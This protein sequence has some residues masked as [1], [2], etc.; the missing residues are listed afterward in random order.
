MKLCIFSDPRIAVVQ[1]CHVDVF[2]CNLRQNNKPLLEEF[3]PEPVV[4]A[5]VG[6][7]NHQLKWFVT[8]RLESENDM[9]YEKISISLTN[10]V[11][12]CNVVEDR[13]ARSGCSSLV[14]NVERL[15]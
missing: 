10:L 11:P 15:N 6:E 13:V 5:G 7:I 9:I 2:I 14:E 3:G 12:S 1:V 4:R 8:E